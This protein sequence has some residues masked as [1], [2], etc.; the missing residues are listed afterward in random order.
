M[1]LRELCEEATGMKWETLSNREM[2]KLLLDHT[3]MQEYALLVGREAE[4]TPP[5]RTRLNE[6]AEYRDS[7]LGMAGFHNR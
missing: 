6:L 3:L 5:Q 2:R 7:Q 1:K 4:L